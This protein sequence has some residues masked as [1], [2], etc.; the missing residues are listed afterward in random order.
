MQTGI[1]VGDFF[2]ISSMHL[3]VI[4]YVNKMHNIP[5]SRVLLTSIYITKLYNYIHKLYLS[6]IFAHNYVELNV[7]HMHTLNKPS[8]NIA[9]HE[10]L[11]NS[12]NMLLD[13]VNIGN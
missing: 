3:Y 1:H 13:S 7:L 6:L 9:I 10:H 8:S 5:A 12:V 11:C 2:I 4:C